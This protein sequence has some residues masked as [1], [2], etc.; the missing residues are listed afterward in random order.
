ML[1]LD[2][3]RAL[4]DELLAL[5]PWWSGF[6]VPVEEARIEAFE[7][8]HRTSLP[9]SYRR[10]LLRIGDRAPIPGQARGGFLPL[11]EAMSAS[12][13]SGFLGPLADPFP[14]SGDQEASLEWDEE[15]D[16]YA[17]PP[18]L[19]GLLP[20]GD[21]GCDVTYH[22][23]VTGQDRGKVWT[24]APSG[25]PELA[26]TG[27]ELLPW[28][29][30]RL[31]AGLAPLRKV[32]AQRALW[33]DRLRADPKDWEAALGLGRETL[34][35]DT[36]R[37][38][39]LIESA[40][41]ARASLTKELRIPLLRAIAELDLLQGR[42]ERVAAMADEDDAWVRCYAGI[43]AAREERWSDCNAL[44]A[45]TEYIPLPMRGPVSYYRGRALIE[46]GDADAASAH[47]RS[48]HATAYTYALFAELYDERGDVA[49]ALRAYRHARSGHQ[50]HPLY[51][52]QKPT[53]AQRLAPPLPSLEIIDAAIARLLTS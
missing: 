10:L 44:L 53:L 38:A 48:N 34:L 41:E 30:K 28:Y 24:F 18:P 14:F 42:A 16:E 45:A 49:E 26:P 46:C 33:E 23:V 12:T 21:G 7:K 27:L 50:P 40:W 36:A 19:R 13:A 52:P 20:I 17:N 43:V 5:A 11:A 6:F 25:D 37:A 47:L 29:E 51:Q 32:G 31:E 1:P 8:E 22:L 4:T 39:T 9:D 15:Q 2:H 35:L 3:I